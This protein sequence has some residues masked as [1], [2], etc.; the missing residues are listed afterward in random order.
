MVADSDSELF[1]KIVKTYP[2]DT[3]LHLMLV[4]ELSL[5]HMQPLP[6]EELLIDPNIIIT[7]DQAC[8]NVW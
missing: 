2:V 6:L 7:D 3:S 1:R 4:G 8:L 5:I